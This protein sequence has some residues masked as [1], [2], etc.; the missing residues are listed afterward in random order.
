MISLVHHSAYDAETVPDGHRFPMRKYSRV[1]ERLRAAGRTFEAPPLAS[2]AALSSV[3]DHDYV[4]A[5]LDQSLDAKRARRIGFPITPA[6]ARRSRAAVGGTG[7]AARLA[8]AEGCAINLAGGSHHAD[9]QGGAGFCV[10]NDVAVAAGALL[11]A[12][13]ATRIAVVDLDVHHGDG[14]ARIFADTP[15]V[16]T[17]SMHCEANWPRDKPPSDL[18]VGLEKGAGDAAYLAAL[19]P[20][21]AETLEAARPDLVFYNAGVDP[22]EQDRLGLLALSDAGLYRR[23]RMVAEAC[24]D[25]GAA[26][27]AVLGGG[28]SADADAVARRH[29][30]LVEALDTVW[31]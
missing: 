11:A 12:G 1:A 18:D 9:G 14:T 16:F 6:I 22:H 24:R 23:D 20:A 7:L 28:Y 26:L 31:A 4:R 8:L 5:I 10:F 17:F 30:L 2:A 13:A 21:L 29:L 27:C 25:Q 19:A 3:H 15:E